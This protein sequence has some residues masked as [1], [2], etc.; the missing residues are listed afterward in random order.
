MTVGENIKKF[1]IARNLTQ[2][3]LGKLTGTTQQMIAQYENNRRNPKIETLDKIAQALHTTVE[4]LSNYTWYFG[5]YEIPTSDL[6]ED[7]SIVNVYYNRL[8]H[9]GKLEAIKRMAEL[10]EIKKYT[11]PDTPDQDAAEAADPDQSTK[12]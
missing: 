10:G 9:L 1:R 11:D 2:K 5:K 6:V 3:D 8:N 4:E 7:I 12:K